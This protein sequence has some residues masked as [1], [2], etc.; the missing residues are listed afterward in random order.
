MRIG[1]VK[2]F[3]IGILHRMIM[4]LHFY[5][6]GK[7]HESYE[8]SIDAI[9]G[10]C[11]H[12]AVRQQP[13]SHEPG[14]NRNPCGKNSHHRNGGEAV[15]ALYDN[16]VSS[17]FAALL[18]LSVTFRD[19]AGEE[20]IADI[21]RKLATAGGLS[22][23]DVQGDFAY[24]APWG[25][26]AVFYKGYGK[27]EGLYILGRIE[28]GKEWLAGQQ[29]DFIARIEIVSSPFKQSNNREKNEP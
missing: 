11:R 21:P 12:S 16:P 6:K 26:L 23:K 4:T 25:N 20:K 7:L 29:N 17:N 15:I 8:N 14:N 28:S 18:P 19:Y 22:A 1:Y 9:G 3:D 27:D 10:H 5:A 24:Y 13:S 2:L